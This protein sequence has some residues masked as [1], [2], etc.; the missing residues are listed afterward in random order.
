MLVESIRAGR[1][2]DYRNGENNPGPAVFQVTT[3][4]HYFGAST[5]L[6]QLPQWISSARSY[7]QFDKERKRVIA[8]VGDGVNDC[9]ALAQ[10][11]VGFALS[12]GTDIAI[13]TADVVLMQPRNLML[14]PTAIDLSGAVIRRI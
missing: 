5:K 8:M 9:P 13:D 4:P 1:E 11:D 6:W 7:T 12:S 14:I 2:N 10:A 3:P